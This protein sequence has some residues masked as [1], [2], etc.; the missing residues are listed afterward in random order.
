MPE[1]MKILIVEDEL[2]V[3]MSLQQQLQKDA[4]DIFWQM[5][6]DKL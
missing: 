6:A 4:F 3:L 2:M 5:M 1:R